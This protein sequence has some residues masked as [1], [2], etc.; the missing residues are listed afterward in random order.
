MTP[1]TPHCPI[2]KWYLMTPSVAKTAY[3]WCQM[4]KSAW[5]TGRMML[6]GEE[7]EPCPSAT[8]FNTN[9]TCCCLRFNL[10]PHGFGP[11]TSRFSHGT[12]LSN[13]NKSHHKYA[14]ERVHT[15][16]TLLPRI[17]YVPHSIFGL[18]SWAF[19][20]VPH[21]FTPDSSQTTSRLFSS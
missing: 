6:S 3:R 11:A 14:N 15:W 12:S 4:N 13:S 21:A 17:R 18:P 9:H 2:Q 16:L 10:W 1:R 20:E 8:P 5:S 19:R 7:G